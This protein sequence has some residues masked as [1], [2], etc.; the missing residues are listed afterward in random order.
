MSKFLNKLFLASTSLLL[1]ATYANA[2][3]TICYKSDWN[4][5]ATIENTPL[6]GGECKGEFSVSQMKQKGWNVI[7]IKVESKENKLNYSYLLSTN[8]KNKDI[9]AK[10]ENKLSFRPIGL[11]LDNIENNK[12]T[13]SVGNLIV[14]QSGMVMH[15]FS[16]NKKMIIANAEVIES[17]KTTSVIKFSEYNDL[18]QDAIPTSNRTI[19]KDDVLVLNYLYTSSLVI[20]PNQETFQIVRSNFKHNN[21]LHSDIFAAKLKIDDTPYPTQ[22][23][24][25]NFAIEQNLGTVFIVVDDKVNV[26]DTKTFTLLTTFNIDYNKNDAQLPF[27]TRVDKIE[28]STIESLSNFS[29]SDLDFLNLLG[30]KKEKKYDRSNYEDYYKHI[31]GL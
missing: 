5:P 2:Q 29:I 24:I 20:A 21:F 22:S 31:L 15:M 10:K 18:K 30:T 27:Y 11:K 19:Q 13:I 23:D 9:Q 12:S 16:N 3:N 14:G 4:S 8:I 1:C 7:D 28:E 17:N 25:R 6:D 26:V